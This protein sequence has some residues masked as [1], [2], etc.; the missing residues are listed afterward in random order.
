MHGDILAMNY[1]QVDFFEFLDRFVEAGGN[2]IGAILMYRG[3]DWYE[4]TA[5]NSNSITIVNHKGRSETVIVKYDY[6]STR[7]LLPG[8]PI[9]HGKPLVSRRKYGWTSD[10]LR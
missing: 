6:W 10:D 8:G 1:F 4:I 5:H 3:A 2:P 7:G 9:V